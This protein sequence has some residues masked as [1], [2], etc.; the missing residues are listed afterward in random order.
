M[1]VTRRTNAIGVMAVTAAAVCGCASS[2]KYAN[3]PRPALPLNLT[4]IVNNSGV[5]VSPDS[6]SG[7]QATFTITNQSQNQAEGLSI[8]AAGTGQELAKVPPINPQGATQVTV[9]LAANT[10]YALIP[11]TNGSTNA[12]LKTARVSVGADR[13]GSR[14]VLLTP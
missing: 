14:N 12:A 9:N 7:G 3:H 6:V 10:D 4:V 1:T 11:T 8:E 5:S 2:P 13:S